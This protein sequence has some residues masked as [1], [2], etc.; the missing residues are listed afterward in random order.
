MAA[1][2]TKAQIPDITVF[3]PDV[4]DDLSKVTWGH[5][6]NSKDDLEKLIAGMA[7]I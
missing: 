4:A 2:D 3:F 5:A 6:V 7:V 1:E